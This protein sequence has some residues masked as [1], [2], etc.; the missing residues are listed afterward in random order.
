MVSTRV[1]NVIPVLPL[2]VLLKPI[3]TRLPLLHPKLP[4]VG[5]VDLFAPE[6]ASSCTTS[7]GVTKPDSKPLVCRVNILG[8]VPK[9]APPRSVKLL[10][11]VPPSRIRSVD[12]DLRTSGGCVYC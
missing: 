2:W 7:I 3:P 10:V 4:I 12:Q 8:A 9:P 5:V 11:G 1:S 6:M